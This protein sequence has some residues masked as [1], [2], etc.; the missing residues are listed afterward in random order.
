MKLRNKI[1]LPV[2]LI[3]V[4]AVTSISVINYFIARQTV[5]AMIDA[6]MDSVISNLH[7]AERLSHEITGIVMRELDSKNIALARALSEIVNLNPA[8]LDTAEMT[9]LAQRL[10]V[11]EVHVA[12]GDGILRWGNVTGFFGFDFGSG[13]QSMPFLRMIEDTSFELAQE[14]QPNAALGVYFSYTGVARMDAPGFVQ[15]GIAADIIDSLAAEFDIQKTIEETHLGES[16]FVFIVENGIITA[17]PNADMVNRNFSPSS[18]RAVSHN[19]Q[20]L[21]FDGVEYYAGFHRSGDRMIYSLIPAYEFNSR[22]NVLGMVSAVM[23]GLAILLMGSLLL[24]VLWRVTRPITLL[25]HTLG[26]AANGDLTKRLPEEGKDEIAQA[27]KS[28][29]A[30]ME[31]LRKMIIAIKD[32]SG[33]LS[34]IGDNLVGNISKT[35]SAMNQITANIQNIKDKAQNQSESVTQTNITMEQVSVKINALS[36][37]VDRQTGAVSQSSSSV[38]E[39]LASIQSVTTTLGQG[40]Q[41]VKELRESAEVGRSSI[42][43]VVSDIQEIARESEGLLEINSVMQN[44]ASQTN[45]LS[46]NAAIE[47]A[48]AGDA[49]KGFA[50]VAGEI[51]K[52]AESSGEQS[53]IIGNVLKKIKE[54]IDKITRSTNMVLNRFDVIDQSV[55]TVAEQVDNIRY[56]MEEQNQGSKQIL[57]ASGQVNDIT[58]QVKGGSV[59]MLAGSREVI[60][61]SKNLEKATREITEGMNEMAVD[62]GQVNNAVNTV[63]E[64]SGKTKE[65][66]SS[67]ARAVSRFKV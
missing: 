60:K 8:V 15:V 53:K 45:L 26:D 49:G 41:N 62:A 19:R 51:R 20:W 55:K 32:Q 7:V 35:A 34:D 1:L 61:E 4:A 11:N 14:A 64:L 17:H 52:L 44:I 3:L 42:Q 66:I 56:S 39:M 9:R 43:E 46:M 28:F 48:H 54:S 36:G 24:F 65:N 30:T 57:E 38:E 22:L 6:E 12:D 67:L 29:N 37:H 50:V 5:T 2:M 59:E 13:E 33:K 40:A 47:A 25:T 27:S 63:C 23:S 18:E 58:R 31:E 10:N 16:G 21:T